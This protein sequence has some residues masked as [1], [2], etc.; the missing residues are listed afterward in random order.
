MNINSLQNR[1]KKKGMPYLYFRSN[2]RL[3]PV[4]G[5]ANYLSVSHTP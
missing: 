2:D 4:R 5:A 3:V 1:K